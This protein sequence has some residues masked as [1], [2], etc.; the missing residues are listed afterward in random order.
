MRR[1]AVVLAVLIGFGLALY[2]ALALTAPRPAGL[3]GL[4]G[5]ACMGAALARR[6]FR[7]LLFAA[8]ALLGLHYAVSLHA[9][10]VRIDAY[11][12]LFA[13][14]LF[15]FVET[16]DLAVTLADVAPMTRPVILRRLS[17]ALVV[18]GAGGIVALGTL[19]ARS[20]LSGASLALLLG[21]AVCAAG[22]IALPL[23]LAQRAGEP[24]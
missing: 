6:R 7:G 8:A 22:A 4:S 10:H 3:L 11:A 15:A 14:G 18:G 5:L 24:G 21:G 12:P 2:P 20:S 19:V 23:V 1:T 17:S 16:M 13:V 9:A